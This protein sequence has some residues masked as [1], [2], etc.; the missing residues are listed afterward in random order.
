[1]KKLQLLRKIIKKYNIYNKYEEFYKNTYQLFYRI[2]NKLFFKKK[3]KLQSK[4]SRK[5]AVTRNRKYVEAYKLDHPCPCGE[6]GSYCLSFHHPFQKNL[7]RNNIYQYASNALFYL[8]LLHLFQQQ[9]RCFQLD[10]KLNKH[11]SQYKYL[12]HHHN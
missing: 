7:R 6:I 1:M 5:R 11:Y 8:F 10:K 4:K 2:S 3:K 9:V 12:F